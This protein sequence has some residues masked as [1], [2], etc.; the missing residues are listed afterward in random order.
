MTDHT[1]PET[2]PTDPGPTDEGG[3]RARRDERGDVPGW[4][5]VTVMSV[6]LIAII[7]QLARDEL[8]SILRAALGSVTW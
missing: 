8:Q 4:V 5:L 7:T 2:V 1:N 6:G 3:E